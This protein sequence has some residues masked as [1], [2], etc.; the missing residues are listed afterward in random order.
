MDKVNHVQER[1]EL[2]SRLVNL[3]PSM[4]D[5]GT[6]SDAEG[7]AASVTTSA[8][9]CSK[10]DE[11]LKILDTGLKALHKL[12]TRSALWDVRAPIFRKEVPTALYDT[13]MT[14]YHPSLQPLW[15]EPVSAEEDQF[16]D[17]VGSTTT[18]MI[19]GH[20]RKLEA[21][22]GK[23]V[24]LKD[25]FISNFKEVMAAS[26]IT[27]HPPVKLG[28]QTTKKPTRTVVAHFSDTH[29]GVN[30]EKGELNNLNE[31]N[32]TI[33]SRRSAFFI[34]EAVNYKLQHRE[35]TDLLILLNGDVIS[36]V[37]HNQEWAVDLLTTQFAGA[38]SILLQ[39]I[40][41]AAR[42][43]KKVRVVCT[44]GNHGRAMHKSSK[45]RASVHKW[46]SYENMLYIALREAL[47]AYPNVQF[48]IPECPYAIVD[49]QGHKML[50]THG[51]T[52]INVGNPGKSLN[53]KSINEQINKHNASLI[54]GN[55]NFAAVICGHVHVSTV[56]ETESST[57][58]MIN[59][60]LSGLDAY[61]QSLGIFSTN[62][63]QTIFETTAEYAVGDIRLIKLRK[64]DTNK[65]LDRII[66][67][68]KGK[69]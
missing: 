3:A 56:Q 41:Y 63:T 38:L 8:V 57:M 1:I 15:V 54:K 16:A 44:P 67:P 31:F 43:F 20:K 60:T 66:V 51:D 9:K 37:I 68:F 21:R 33:A 42:S 39:A 40:T 61:A 12:S 7:L 30:I 5:P 49:V 45:E 62:A 58:L 47:K 13:T 4:T 17:L 24:A 2:L 19:R 29:Y 32:W 11:K 26:T 18:K 23:E 48:E 64:A 22:F 36:G 14:V 25:E 65:E 52:V 10:P 35:D 27:L 28:K 46:D 59:G 34:N 53:M 69:F 50:V 6:K 55:K